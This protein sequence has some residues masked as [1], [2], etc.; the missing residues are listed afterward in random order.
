[1]ALAVGALPASGALGAGATERPGWEAS[2]ASLLARRAGAVER[3]DEA[4]FVATMT[5]APRRFVED[6][7][8]WLRALRGLPLGSYRLELAA[9][10]FGDLAAGLL[11]RVDAD[12]VHLVQA[13]ERIALRGYD[14]VPSADDVFLTVAR[15]A[16]RWSVVADDGLD[17]L[18]LRSSRNLWDFG[19][20]DAV[21]RGGA[22]VLFHQGGRA[23]ALRIAREAAVA[24]RR[25]RERWPYP[26]PGRVVVAVPSAA[27]ELE[28]ILQTTFDVGPFVAFAASSVDRSNGW[29][30]GGH[31]IY[32]Q[33]ETF[34]RYGS[35]F[36]AETLAHEVLH[37]ATRS[38]SGP[39]VPS[40][41]D[42][43]AAQM[44]GESRAPSG[45]RLRAQVRAGR[46]PGRLPEDFEFVDSPTI[47]ASYDASYDFVA[48]LGRRLGHD[49]GARLLRSA[50]AEDSVGA[51]TRRYHLRRAARTAFGADFTSLERSW[52]A[53][54][55]RRAG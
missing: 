53:D 19:P 30:F 39:A 31:R 37:V 49:A 34:F 26:W 5:E 23:A 9:E 40:W 25:V 28:R 42:E 52:A 10:G 43:G 48:W 55:R 13:V 22:L 11:E 38:V 33:P 45:A 24:V 41:L 12:E 1:M 18:D 47:G 2:V 20:V 16:G 50:G 46:F 8:R 17:D 36:R 15:R 27:P 7:R 35:A 14:S 3:G 21:E 32:I 54:V 29:R 51:G 4:A 44:Y 6:K